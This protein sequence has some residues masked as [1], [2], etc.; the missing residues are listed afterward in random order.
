MNK[1]WFISYLTHMC[2]RVINNEEI[3]VIEHQLSLFDRDT[4]ISDIEELLKAMADGRKIDAIRYHR[5]LTKMGL[6]ESKELIEKY[7]RG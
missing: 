2:G 1:L 7:L 5:A 3:G 6:R 4:S